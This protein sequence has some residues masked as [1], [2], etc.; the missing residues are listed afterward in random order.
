MYLQELADTVMG[1]GKPEVCRTG[2]QPGNS[3]AGVG[4]TSSGRNFFLR[5]TSVLLLMTL[6]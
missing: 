4:A 3:K 1:A 2:W 6:N 5:E